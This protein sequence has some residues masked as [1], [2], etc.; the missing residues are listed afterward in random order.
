MKPVT[1][2]TV[3]PGTSRV[4]RKEVSHGPRSG[5]RHNSGR[6]VGATALVER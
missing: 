5:L 4:L 3:I 1:A 6:N 2:I